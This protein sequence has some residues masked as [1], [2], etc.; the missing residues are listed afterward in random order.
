MDSLGLP[1]VSW[2][3]WENVLPFGAF[4]P[5]GAS[6]L[7]P[8][9]QDCPTLLPR[10]LFSVL[11]A[12]KPSSETQKMTGGKYTGNSSPSHSESRSAPQRS[13]VVSQSDA[14]SL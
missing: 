4:L 3:N 13:Q 11:W 9:Y 7:L 6:L 14:Q 1:E 12:G 2:C 10:G 5:L 8:P